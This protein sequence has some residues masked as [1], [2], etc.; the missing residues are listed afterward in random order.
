MREHKYLLE[1]YSPYHIIPHFFAIS[2]FGC[3]LLFLFDRQVQE[4]ECIVIAL[5]AFK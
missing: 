2:Q 3:V 1:N 4:Q 5:K